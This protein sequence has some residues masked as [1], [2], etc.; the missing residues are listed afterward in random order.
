MG[1]MV[2]RPGLSFPPRFLAL[3]A[4]IGAVLTLALAACAQSFK[5]PGKTVPGPA[6][7]LAAAT[8]SGGRSA[9]LAGDDRT[10]A[11]FIIDHRNGTVLGSFGVTKEATGIAAQ[12]EEGPLLLSIGA[13][14]NGK[15]MGAIEQ[16]SLQ[17]VKER[18]V[19][20]PTK[21]LGITSVVRGIA[22][23]LLAGNGVVRAAAPIDMPSLRV[24]AVVPLGANAASLQHCWSDDGDYLLYTQGD[25]GWLTIRN[26]SSRGEARSP[27]TAGGETCSRDGSV[28]YAI[29]ASALGR[30]VLVMRFPGLGPVSSIPASRDA[31]AL[32]ET[33]DHH[34][35]ALNSTRRVATIE[36]FRNEM[37]EIR[38]ASNE[39]KAPPAR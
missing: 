12:T 37:L 28:A 32:Y 36:T 27:V 20:L 7:A 23:I 9:I 38:T 34:L 1:T 24:G 17:G 29:A 11:I 8:L 6:G 30:S 3:R 39:L 18:I 19:P 10:K 33:D 25:R 22:Y 15:L 5:A 31:I 4:L 14:R 35:V 13:E 26:M 2:T 16:W 21:A